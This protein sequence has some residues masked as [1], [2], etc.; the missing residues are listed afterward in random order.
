MARGILLLVCTVTAWA[1]IISGRVAGGPQPAQPSTGKGLIEGTVVDSST[2]EPVKK[3]LVT[4]GGNRR[5]PLEAV[6]DASGHFAFRQL[7]AGRYMVNAS[8]PGYSQPHSF[9][10]DD[11]SVQINLGPDEEKKGVE[12][13]LVAGAVISGR[14]LDEDGLPVR[15][16]TVTVAQRSYE[17]GQAVLRPVASENTTGAKGGY[18]IFGVPPGRYY[19]FVRCQSE[20]PAPHPLLP[21]G[22]PRTPYETYLPQF[23]GGGLDPATATRL[24][25]AP[26]A[27]LDGIDFQMRRVP[28][29]TLQGALTAADPEALSGNVFI[30]LFPANPLVGDL[31]QFSYHREP[32]SPNFQIHGVIP[33]SYRLVA[34]SVH[35]NHTF[36]AERA[37]QVGAAPPEPLQIALTSGMELKGSVQFDSEDHPSLEHAQIWLMPAQPSARYFRPQPRAEVNSDGS[38]T[39][40]G[41]TPGRW[42]LMATVNAITYVK[43]LSLGGQ[44]LSPY[45]F[46]IGPGAAGFLRVVLGT[47]TGDVQVTLSGATAGPGQPVSV[48]IFPED[49]DRFGMGLERMIPASGGQANAG[50][51]PPGRYRVLATDVPSPWP[52]LQRPDLLQ[53]LEGSTEALEIPEG[54]KASV[55]VP[56]IPREE[57]VR[58]LNDKE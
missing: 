52:I 10:G 44:P 46:Q 33:G 51:M 12:I 30:S 20:V 1:Q 14:V 26:G 32:R 4:L 5:Q 21:R 15:Y 41:V 2:R 37:I 6:T 38:F 3:A 24:A 18:R 25:L 56:V 40:T 17:Q 28:G 54:G 50:A 13:A 55:T 45:A 39:L 7:P 8:K 57:L 36:F 9:L 31:W 27:N 23:Y 11:Q 19:V 29:V 53:A 48:L 47:K 43:S 42:R 49:L 34:S 22:D 16:C 58:A 35:G